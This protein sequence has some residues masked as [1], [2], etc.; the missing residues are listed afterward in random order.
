M[1]IL[2][3][4]ACIF[5]LPVAPAAHCAQA[6]DVA[7]VHSGLNG[8]DRKRKLEAIQLLFAEIQATATRANSQSEAIASTRTL[9]E[10]Y[11]Q[12]L[13]NAGRASDA[14]VRAQATLL[15]GYSTPTDEIRQLLTLSLTDRIPDVQY[16]ALA[17][18]N[19]TNTDTPEIR[20]I[21]TGLLQQKE[22]SSLFRDA[23]KIAASL[24]ISE[25]IGPLMEALKND[26]AY[27]RGYAAVALADMEVKTALPQLKQALEGVTE[28]FIRDSIEK[29]IARLESSL[30]ASNS[31][32]LASTAKSAELKAIAK[33]EP[34]VAKPSEA[35]NSTEKHS[36]ATSWLVWIAASLVALSLV[37][38]L[39]KKRN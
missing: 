33:P 17:S 11:K 10:P 29:A 28:K 1:K 14:A 22:N 20:K 38:L 24:P 6:I 27:F 30:V 31:L 16:A 8:D 26:N 5:I 12:E 32:P 37:W 7:S 13:V 15:L 9:I 23:A 34:S 21:V 3:I 19:Y 35:S 2:K 18:V 36:E 39:L 4:I 25:A